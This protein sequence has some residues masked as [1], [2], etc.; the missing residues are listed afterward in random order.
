MRQEEI[1]EKVAEETGFSRELVKFVI[2][3][4]WTK[5]RRKMANPLACGKKIIVKDAFKFECPPYWVARWM[6][7]IEKRT[8]KPYNQALLYY[9]K[10]LSKQL[11]NEGQTSRG[12]AHGRGSKYAR[13]KKKKY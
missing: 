8:P 4:F 3:D 2:K 9:L 12:L 10:E 7:K 6:A 5:L 11:D 13:Q 1:Y